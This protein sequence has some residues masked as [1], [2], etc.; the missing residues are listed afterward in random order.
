MLNFDRLQTRW[1][2]IDQE[3]RAQGV[4]VGLETIRFEFCSLRILC[5]YVEKVWDMFL[6]N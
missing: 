3:G 6:S 4:V 1:S 2:V 5:N